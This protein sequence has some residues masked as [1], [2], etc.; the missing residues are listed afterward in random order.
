VWSTWPTAP[1]PELD[2]ESK[3][4]VRCPER[5][6]RL[7]LEDLQPLDLWLNDLNMHRIWLGV[8]G[9][10]ERPIRS[11]RACGFREEVRRCRHVWVDGNLQDEVMMGLLRA[12]WP[13]HSPQPAPAGWTGCDREPLDT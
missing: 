6:R 2:S 12:E 8:L 10:N 13:G 11:Y 5:G 4:S 1:R 3:I 7:N 9:S